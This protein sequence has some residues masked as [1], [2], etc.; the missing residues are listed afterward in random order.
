MSFLMHLWAFSTSLHDENVRVGVEVGL[1]L[2]GYGNMWCVE[3]RRF[4]SGSGT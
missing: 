2:L 3:K 1:L 4:Y